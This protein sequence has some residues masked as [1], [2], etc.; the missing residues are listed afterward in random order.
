MNTRMEYLK[1]LP[2]DIRYTCW[3]ILK[4]MKIQSGRICIKILCG[5]SN[6]HPCEGG[7]MGIG[8]RVIYIDSRLRGNDKE[9]VRG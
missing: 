8:M 7:D 2:T 4:Y 6:G 3:C 9:G 5:N 1:D